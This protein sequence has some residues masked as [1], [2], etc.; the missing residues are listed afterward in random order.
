M[1]ETME[2]FV[3]GSLRPLS[4][5]MFAI[6][7]IANA[8]RYMAQGKHIGKVVISLPESEVVIAPRHRKA[9]ELRGDGTYLITGGLGGFGIALAEWMV[10]HGARHLALCGRRMPSPET[11]AAIDAM[12]AAGASVRVFS[13][14]VTREDDV[15]TL[16][17]EI[18]TSMPPLRGVVHGAMVLDDDLL[19]QLDDTRMR[20]AMD[21]K[22]TGAWILHAHTSHLPLDLFVMFSSFSSIIGTTRQGNYVAAN[23]FLDAL[24]HHRQAMGL[25]ALTV[26]WGVVG[27]V[28]YVA[29]SSDLGQ[30][31]DQFGFKSLP[32]QQMLGIFGAL[33]QE[34][35]VQIGIAHMNWQQLAKMHMIGG[36][37]RYAYLVKPVMT[38]DVSGAGAWLIDAL[39]A[40]EPSERQLFLEGLIRELLARVLGTSPSKVD[41]DKPL[42]SLGLDS[43]MAVEIGNRMQSELGVSIPPVKFME[44]L[45]TAGMAQYLV[46]QLSSDRAAT[47]AA[48]LRD[49]KPG[50]MA[51][52]GGEEPLHAPPPPDVEKVL[53]AVN[54]LSD[55]EVDTLLKRI[56]MEETVSEEEEEAV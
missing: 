34:K 40:V 24:A 4:Y 20:R 5:R 49:L 30:K 22:A 23:A 45:T 10:E 50:L 1:K 13:V 15:V 47:P 39:M 21:P 17:S 31:L 11:N 53:V 25:P 56:E 32:V 38:D 27:G 7:D 54:N 19:H 9:V 6:E 51:V 55:R 46:E 28:G 48:S 2:E 44:G 8:F 33:L 43:L 14:D 41:V 3:D 16:L 36:S 18:E 26:N 42:I 37:P 52:R 12:T 35:A 29:Q